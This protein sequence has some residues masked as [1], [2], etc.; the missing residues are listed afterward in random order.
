MTAIQEHPKRV[1]VSRGDDFSL[2]M[3]ERAKHL[4]RLPVRPK[5]DINHYHYKDPRANATDGEWISL[6]RKVEPVAHYKGATGEPKPLYPMS[7]IKEAL[8][9]IRAKKSAKTELKVERKGPG[10]PKGSVDKAKKLEEQ[11][12]NLHQMIHNQAHVIE[13]LN[14]MVANQSREIEELK[15]KLAPKPKRS[16]FSFWR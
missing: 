12:L 13:S 4:R 3:S 5:I 9:E 6:C 2:Y 8:K 7:K 16:L 11:I 14:Q 15:E 10:R 1:R